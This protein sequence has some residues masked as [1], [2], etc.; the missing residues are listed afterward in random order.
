[1]RDWERI[2]KKLSHHFGNYIFK[3]PHIS[4]IFM[5]C[6]VSPAINFKTNRLCYWKLKA[7]ILEVDSLH[8][9]ILSHPPKYAFVVF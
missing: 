5:C 2:H 9:V 1:M 6:N 3:V 4:K 8:L 7:I